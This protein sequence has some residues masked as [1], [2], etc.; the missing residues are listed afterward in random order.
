M[1]KILI[2]DGDKKFCEILKTKLTFLGY[3]IFLAFNGSQALN[4]FKKE[5]LD[6]IIIDI[7]LPKLDG[8]KVV[9]NIRRVSMVPI[10]IVTTLSS[11]SHRV[12]G[13]ELGADDYILKPFA[14][15]ELE[16]KIRSILRRIN[17]NFSISYRKRRSIFRVGELFFI[18]AQKKVLKKDRTIRLTKIEY[19]L[20]ELLI[21][22]SGTPLSREVIL[23]NIWGYIPERYVDVRVVDVHISRLRSKLEDNPSKPDFILTERRVGYMFRQR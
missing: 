6:F 21:E 15:K 7:I 4:I 1:S 2:V 23:A 8:F 13:L 16:I 14:P 22:N 5:Q 20:F 17:K 10:I 9:Q 19:S 11:L 12:L 3:N 18:P